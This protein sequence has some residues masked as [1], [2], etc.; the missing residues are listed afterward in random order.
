MMLQRAQWTCAIVVMF[1]VGCS[2]EVLTIATRVPIPSFADAVNA[3]AAF[4]CQSGQCSW[5][6]AVYGACCTQPADE[7]NPA[8]SKPSCGENT[9]QYCYAYP[10]R[11]VVAGDPAYNAPAYCAFASPFQACMSDTTTVTEPNGNRCIY[12][13]ESI[14]WW[15]LPACHAGPY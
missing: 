12:Y 10:E 4:S 5:N 7:N 2:D 11:C 1:L 3:C 9:S 15:Q 13:G 14:Q 8:V 6:P